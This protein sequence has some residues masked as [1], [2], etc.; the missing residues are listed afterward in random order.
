MTQDRRM[1]VSVVIPAYN[2][3]S[4]IGRTIAAAREG[5]ESTGLAFE[6]IVV[7]D[8]SSDDTAAEAE[9]SGGALVLRHGRNLGKGAALNTGL[10]AAG[11]G[12]LVTL[13]ADTEASS[14]EISKL[15]M[16]VAGGEADMAV[17]AFPPAKRRGGFGIVKAIA[18][19]GIYAFTGLKC[20]APLSGQRAMLTEVAHAVGGFAPGYGAEVGLTIDAALA[21]YRVVEVKTDMSHAETG[22]DI[23]GFMHRGKQLM[24]VVRVLVTR[25][26]RKIFGWRR[27]YGMEG[28]ARR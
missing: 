27:L 21:G 26:A 1:L 12:I 4:R 14:R 6:I 13:D 22:R 16:P 24:A 2:E 8:G 9:A 23:A 7:D 15:I 17:A 3:S 5:A 18:R 10:S 19:A 11:G 25:L 20:T 28:E